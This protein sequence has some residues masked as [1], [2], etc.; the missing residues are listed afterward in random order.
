MTVIILLIYPRDQLVVWRITYK[1]TL[2][3]VVSVND[4][5]NGDGNGKSVIDLNHSLTV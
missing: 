1:L 5:C 4:Y 3:I 2:T